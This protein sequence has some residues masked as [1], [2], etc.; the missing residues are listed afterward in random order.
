[1]PWNVPKTFLARE[2]ISQ[3]RTSV[4]GGLAEAVARRT[5]PSASVLL[6]FD[7]D[8]TLLLRAHLEHRAALADAVREVWGVPDPGPA[9][10]PGAG[11]TDGEI[12]RQMCLLGGVAAEAF[13]AR[14]DDFRE[15]C[16]RAFVR[17]CPPDLRDRV[18]P[19]IPA[20]LA[21]L[22]AVP[23]T[24]L[25]LVTGNLEAIA[26]LKLERAGLAE[27]FPAGQ[28]AFGSDREDRSELPALARRRA[29]APDGGAPYPRARTVVIGDTPRDIACARADGVR[30]VAVATGPF[31]AAELAAADAVARRAHELPGLI[32]AALSPAG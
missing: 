21:E 16:A 30:C 19:G 28:G 18:A 6:L 3:P 15:A 9:A 11:R 26:R 31:G 22:A 27:R 14:A 12:A 17:H 25:S 20:A 1:M 13:D 29:G 23:A 4:K 2:S 7:I 32:A 10:V 5:Y 8:G 24:R